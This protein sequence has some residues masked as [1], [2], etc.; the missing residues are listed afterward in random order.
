MIT[1]EQMVLVLRYLKN[2]N[3]SGSVEPGQAAVWLDAINANYPKMRIQDAQEAA[4]NL[5]VNRTAAQGNTWITPGDFIAEVRRLRNKRMQPIGTN[6][7]RPAGLPSADE[8]KWENTF[9][10]AI[11]DGHTTEQATDAANKATRFTPRPELE[12]AP[13]RSLKEL[14]AEFQNQTRLPKAE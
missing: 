11:C 10:D 5:A 7:P 1:N 8:H 9:T 12:T 4:R 14:F 6:I 3:L 13:E 2:A